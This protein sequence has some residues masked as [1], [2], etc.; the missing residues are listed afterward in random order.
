MNG[1]FSN[2]HDTISGAPL[3]SI[4]G[5]VLFN[6]FNCDLYFG[7]RDLDIASYGGD[8]MPYTFSSELDVA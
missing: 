8:N 2:F 1:F 3:N 5:P 7:I 4:L 6:L